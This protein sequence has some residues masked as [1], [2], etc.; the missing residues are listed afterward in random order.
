[1]DFH[2]DEE[3]QARLD[4]GP[5][6]RRSLGAIDTHTHYFPAPYRAAIDA[7]GITHPD[8]Y[9]AGGPSWPLDAQLA[10]MENLGIETA[11]LSIS[12]PGVQLANNDPAKVA[13]DAN[14]EGA[15]LARDHPG[16]L[17]F[18]ASIPMDGVDRAIAEI[19]H[20]YERLGA[21]GVCLMTH[22]NGVYLGD[23]SLEPVFEALG[24][25]R[26]RVLVHPTEPAAFP[27]QVMPGWSRSMYEYFFDT[28]RTFINLI[29]SGQLVRNPGVRMIIPHAGSALP[30]LAQRIER[31]VKRGNAEA[32]QQRYPSMIESLRSCWFDTAGSV[33]PHQM[34]SLLALA[35][36]TRILWGSDFPYTNAQMGAELCADMRTSDILTEAQR[37]AILRDNALALFADKLPATAG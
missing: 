30:A 37:R 15:Q 5:L 32:G 12:T 23:P 1:M 10:H 22:T 14:E 20:A 36:P 34:A 11:V 28:T 6:S 35:D 18:F 33:L 29:F 26:A 8:G 4:S 16:R 13:R 9:H 19:E 3:N 2:S 17:G 27:A 7:A 31:N 25:Y 21:W 24:R